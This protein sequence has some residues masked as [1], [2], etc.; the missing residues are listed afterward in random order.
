MQDSAKT[1]QF[2]NTQ[3]E[4]EGW[5]ISEIGAEGDT[6]RL[7]K[8]DAAE[9]FETDDMAWGY[10][11]RQAVQGSVYHIRALKFLEVNAPEEF[12]RIENHA[13]AF[14]ICHQISSRFATLVNDHADGTFRI[15]GWSKAMKRRVTVFTY[16]GVAIWGL[17]SA[18][19]RAKEFGLADQ[20]CDYQAERAA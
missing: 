9:I 15:T 13:A 20:F 1:A 16:T 18:E 7:E 17:R 11:I 8:N 3:A 12:E 4:T 19:H 14:M 2:D 10:V 6:W 5:F